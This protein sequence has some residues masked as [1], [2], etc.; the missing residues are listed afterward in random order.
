MTRVH[1]VTTMP[2]EQLAPNFDLFDP[3]H[4]ER[5][6][7]VL[8][9]ARTACPV[10]KTDA[11][12]GY[13][14]VT[15]YDDVR[16]VL[17][18]AETFSSVEAGL[19]GVP[20]PMPPLTEDPPNHI[21]YRKALN[22]YLTRSFLSRYEESIRRY[23]RN[24]LDDLVPRG[25]FEFM[26]EFAVPFTS[27]N[28][29][30]V[31]LADDNETRLQSAIQLAADISSYGRNEAF[32]E[33]AEL[34]EELLN[35][36]MTFGGDRDDILSAIIRATVQ[37][38]PLTMQ[39]RV[40]ATMILFTGGLDTTKAALGS[41]VK[42]IADDPS[43]EARVRDPEWVKRDLDE[44]LRLDSP[45]AF[46][47]RTVTKDTELNGCPL[48]PGDRVAVHYASANRDASQFAHPAELDFERQ[49]NPH[50]AF[51]IGPHRCIGLHFARLQI[52][53][54]FQELFNRITNV[55][56]PQGERVHT[57]TGVVQAHEYL[58]I[59]FD[60][61]SATQGPSDN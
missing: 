9:F 19:R 6:W 38:R 17:T 49:R 5:L 43:L 59:E 60:F 58:P 40:G 28:L 2:V 22:H 31:I 57:A 42:H 50:A 34:A 32:F 29:A 15:R 36:R 47:A 56:I 46:M 52:E 30:K 18:D 11:D 54:G 13:H 8:D 45:I 61:A 27:G 41:I 23:A 39:E 3:Q 10:L 51:G 21:E 35:E 55:R 33:L 12:D 37:G 4:S 7:E 26:T 1:G 25:R 14:I 53:I 44:F 24:L 48:R 20:V 16:A